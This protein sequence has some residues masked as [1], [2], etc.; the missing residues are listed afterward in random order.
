VLN[1]KYKSFSQT[2]FPKRQISDDLRDIIIDAI[3]T[4]KINNKLFNALSEADK[5]YLLDVVT[6]AKLSS[7]FP[8]IFPKVV[9]GEGVAVNSDP[10][11]RFEILKGSLIAGNNNPEIKKEMRI[12]VHKFMKDN[13]ISSKDG[14]GI[15]ELL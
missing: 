1:L 7:V 14:F 5:K 12:L 8:N 15:L 11:E 3:E 13:L 2:K 10:F 9:S 6:E 4:K